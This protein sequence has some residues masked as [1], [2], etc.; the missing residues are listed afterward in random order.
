MATLTIYSCNGPGG[1]SIPEYNLLILINNS[2]MMIDKS[3]EDQRRYS[4]ISRYD[5]VMN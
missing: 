2:W 4:I 3:Y 5:M 1:I